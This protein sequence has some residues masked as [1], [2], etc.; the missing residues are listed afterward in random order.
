MKTIYCISGLGADER[1]FSRLRLDGYVIEFLPWL[2]PLPGEKIEGYAIR[3]SQPLVGKN[4]VLVGLSFGGMMSIEI[5]KLI[6]VEKV[7]LI[8][9]IQSAAQLPRWM[10]AAGWLRLNKIFPMRSYKITEPIQNHFIGVSQPE[11][12]ELVRSYRKNAPQLYM[13]W[14]INEVLHW[15][16]NWQPP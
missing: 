12:I 16:N 11:E 7:I 15:R 2:T 5:A 8:S 1:A 13:D 14:A 4:P 10:K 9:S 6:P 3:M